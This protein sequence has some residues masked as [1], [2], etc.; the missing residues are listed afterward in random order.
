MRPIDIIEHARNRVMPLSAS[1]KIE[2]IHRHPTDTSSY[3]CAV[4]YR[5]KPERVQCALCHCCKAAL[6]IPKSISA[7]RELLDV[8]IGTATAIGFRCLICSNFAQYLS[9]QCISCVLKYG[10]MY[11]H[12]VFCIF[13]ARQTLWEDVSRIIAAY[14]AVV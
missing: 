10:A 12:A 6:I 7:R 8:Q 14:L 3:H 4:F 2:I 5:R 9:D 1:E 13:V 11:E